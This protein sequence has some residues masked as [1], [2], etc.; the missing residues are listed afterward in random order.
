MAHSSEADSLRK[1]GMAGAEGPTTPL[2]MQDKKPING[3]EVV[4]VDKNILSEA[5]A[6]KRARPQMIFLSL[7]SDFSEKRSIHKLVFVAKSK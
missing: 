2:F 3:K 6:G 1:W 5:K 7:D 4:V